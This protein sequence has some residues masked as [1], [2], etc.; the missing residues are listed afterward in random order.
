MSG[1]IEERRNKK[2]R[3]ERKEKRW[4]IKKKREKDQ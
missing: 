1:R 3:E 4:E 2:N